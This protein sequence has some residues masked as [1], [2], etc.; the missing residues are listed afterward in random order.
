MCTHPSPGPPLGVFWAALGSWG[1]LGGSLGGPWG[2]L[3]GLGCP[4]GALRRSLWVP[5]V[6][7]G[8]P[9]EAMAGPLGI[10]GSP[11]G[12]LGRPWGSIGGA[13]GDPGAPPSVPRVPRGPP[14]SPEDP[15]RRPRGSPGGASGE[16]RGR[17][18]DSWKTL[19]FLRKTLLFEV[20][21][22]RGA[23]RWSPSG[24]PRVP[25][26]P[27]GTRAT[28]QGLRGVSRRPPVSP[29][30]H[31]LSILNLEHLFCFITIA[32]LCYNNRTTML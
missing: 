18:F 10:P 28:P 19:Y 17:F 15:P 4:L 16:P 13:S 12:V 21:G 6:A 32:Q 11:R 2:L 31:P 1:P 14:G 8:N 9:W 29:R 24:A 30:G 3:G 26:P 27:P 22:V 25:R 5:W 23:P 20:G 7:L